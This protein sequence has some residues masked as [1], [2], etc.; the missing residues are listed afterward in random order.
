MVD[1]Q[2]KQEAKGFNVIFTQ[3]VN[4]KALFVGMGLISGLQ[5]TGINAILFYSSEIFQDANISLNPDMA[6][7]FVGSFSFFATIFSSILVDRAGRR[8]LL[9]LSCFVMF[10]CFVF[11]GIFFQLQAADETLV[12]SFSFLPVILLCTFIFTLCIGLGSVSFVMVGE[13]FAQ[14]VKDLASGIS[15]TLNYALSVFVT[16]F[17]P[18][19]ADNFG[20]A[21]TFYVFSSFIAATF[22]FV[23]FRVPETKGK[24]FQEIQDSFLK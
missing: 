7:I 1:F 5:L 16:L 24:T 6:V 14:N 12:E 2:S 18:F 21:V 23:L 11:M 20:F 3:R 17:F 4:R 13:I 15:M 19:L 10:F 9:L 22:F 8:A